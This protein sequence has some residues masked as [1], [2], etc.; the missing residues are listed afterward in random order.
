ML[1]K[2]CLL[3]FII[4][5]GITVSAD[6]HLNAGKNE[7]LSIV[8]INDNQWQSFVYDPQ[9][10]EQRV[11][12]FIKIKFWSMVMNT[13]DEWMIL[14]QAK[15]RR[16]L[17]MMSSEDWDKLTEDEQETYRNVL[18]EEFCF[19]EEE[20]IFATRGK[21]QFY[22][23][24]KA[25]PSIDKGIEIFMEYDV[26]P[27]YAQSILLIESPGQLMRSPVGAMGSFQLMSK[28]EIG[29]AHV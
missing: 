25:M 17:D 19:E 29:R 6:D 8:N 1:K 11:D 2:L 27:W 13:S 28:V 5:L 22:Q 15:N 14:N 3:F 24:K 20:R 26:D 21:S 9:I 16:I 10:Y 23:L 4:P 18:R 7:I 12:T